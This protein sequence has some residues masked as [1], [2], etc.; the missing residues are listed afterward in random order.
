MPRFFQHDMQNLEHPYLVYDRKG[1]PSAT[2]ER[3]A[4]E[5]A[6]RPLIDAILRI[7]RRGLRGTLTETEYLFF[8]YDLKMENGLV[9]EHYLDVTLVHDGP[10]QGD[11][12]PIAQISLIQPGV[13]RW[14]RDYK[15]DL[16]YQSIATNPTEFHL[17][18]VSAIRFIFGFYQEIP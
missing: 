16:I 15:D 14:L 2:I 7:L 18:F 10:D 4:V 9:K 12:G 5:A 13:T 6:S 17:A 1:R 8:S 11:A 3:K